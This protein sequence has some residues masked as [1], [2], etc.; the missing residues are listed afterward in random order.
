[1]LNVCLFA[2]SDAGASSGGSAVTIDCAN[3]PCQDAVAVNKQWHDV[4]A[5]TEAVVWRRGAILVA[6][7]RGLLWVNGRVLAISSQGV[8]GRSVPDLSAAAVG[9]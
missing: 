7:K 6:H 5:A 8:L 9:G 1:M 4:F 2:G 3:L